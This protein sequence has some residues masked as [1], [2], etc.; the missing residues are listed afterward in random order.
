MT[1]NTTDSKCLPNT[2]HCVKTGTALVC[3][4]NPDALA[5]LNAGIKNGLIECGT[6]VGRILIAKGHRK[7]GSKNFRWKQYSRTK[8]QWMVFT[9]G[10][11]GDHNEA[12]LV[13]NG[14]TADP[15]TRSKGTV[16]NRQY[17]VYNE[18]KVVKQPSTMTTFL[19]GNEVTE[20]KPIAK[21]PAKADTQCPQPS[22]EQMQGNGAYGRWK[23]YCK[24]LG[25]SQEEANIAWKAAK[26]AILAEQAKPTVEATP[27]KPAIVMPPPPKAQPTANA[28]QG[29]VLQVHPAALQSVLANIGEAKVDYNPATEM[30]TVSM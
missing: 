25:F 2:I 27:P 20:S 13:E 11:I 8:G 30:F 16:D 5:K 19:G 28:K 10:K 15:A 14:L 12:V 18:P 26:N 9:G 17:G 7:P 4:A 23:S 29:T 21:A 24:S 3:F 6:A 22:A 1:A